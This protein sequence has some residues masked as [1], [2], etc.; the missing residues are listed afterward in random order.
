MPLAEGNDW[1]FKPHVTLPARNEW[2][3]AASA[4]SKLHQDLALEQSVDMME[5]F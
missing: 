3:K 4:K 5:P 2:Q 1:P